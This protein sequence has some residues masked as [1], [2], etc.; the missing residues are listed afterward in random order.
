M[1]QLKINDVL[2]DEY[3]NLRVDDLESYIKRWV[4][5]SNHSTK[6][7]DVRVASG[8]RNSPIFLHLDDSTFQISNIE[9]IARDAVRAFSNHVDGVDVSKTIRSDNLIVS[10]I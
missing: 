4:E 2:H 8:P 5:S 3:D 10:S 6:V 9:A 7:H 1:L